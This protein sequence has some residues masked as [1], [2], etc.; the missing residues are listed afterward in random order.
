MHS[1]IEKYDK[2]IDKKK[3]KLLN[4]F[5]KIEGYTSEPL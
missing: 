1:A 5:A 4:I 3:Q 2:S